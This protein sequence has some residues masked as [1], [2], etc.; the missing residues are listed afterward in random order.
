VQGNATG[1][2]VPGGK[3]PP[4]TADADVE[5]LRM[6]NFQGTQRSTRRLHVQPFAH[7]N[8]FTQQ[9]V[10]YIGITKDTAAKILFEPYLPA[11]Q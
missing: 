6:R 3:V 2:S 11:L 9:F 10:H 1:K 4:P 5:A 8:L 7:Y